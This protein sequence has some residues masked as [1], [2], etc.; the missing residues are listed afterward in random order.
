MRYAFVVKPALIL[1][2]LWRL[3]DQGCCS[4]YY[5]LIYRV[6]VLKHMFYKKLALLW[7][8][9]PVAMFRQDK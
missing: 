9:Y 2:R 4:M 7:L 1:A 8:D 3:N 5:A 6:R